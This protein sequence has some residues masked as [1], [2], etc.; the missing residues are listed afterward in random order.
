MEK[1]YKLIGVGIISCIITFLSSGCASMRPPVIK[2][3]DDTVHNYSYFFISPAEENTINSKIYGNKYMVHVENVKSVDPSS[4]ISG[5]LL[6][7]GFIPVSEIRPENAK[8][9]MII[10]YG[11]TDRRN[12]NLGYSIE[13]TIQFV[14]AYSQRLICTCT[15]EGQ[16]MTED[17]DVRIA[18]QRALK[19]LFDTKR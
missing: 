13:Y 7:N 11:E 16:G 1:I 8:E 6:K 4:I 18:I 9:T 19:P 12:V 15:A 10:N 3:Y 5:I 17:D 14:S 2:N